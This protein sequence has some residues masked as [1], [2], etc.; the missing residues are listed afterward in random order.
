MP[1]LECFLALAYAVR[2]RVQPVDG[3]DPFGFDILCRGRLAEYAADDAIDA[4]HD[5]RL[6]WPLDI[7][8]Q[9]HARLIGL[10]FGPVHERFVEH[11]VLA[12]AP[13]VR[14]TIDE[15][16]AVVGIGRDEAE[17]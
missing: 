3:A 8:E 14:L 1:A 4:A 12:V 5:R 17:V 15:Y 10:V 13:C 11:D 2:E 16:Q 7:A 6:Q 9:D